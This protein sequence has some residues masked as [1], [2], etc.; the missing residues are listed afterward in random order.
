MVTARKTGSIKT[1][2]LVMNGTVKFTHNTS[3]TEGYS[4]TLWTVSGTFSGTP[5]FELPELPSG[6][7]WD[8]SGLC[9]AT[10]VLVVKATGIKTTSNTGLK[11]IVEI[12]SFG[13]VKVGSY[14]S[15]VG[16]AKDD[17]FNRNM[18][19]GVYILK[20]VDSEGGRQTIEVMK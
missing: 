18:P 14:N 17:F 13:G 16:T 5:T 20:I 8:T 12:Y 9:N 4:K 6:L 10:G 19:A 7:E 3:F 2:N 11:A 1:T 15:T